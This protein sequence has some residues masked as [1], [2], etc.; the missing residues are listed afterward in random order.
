MLDGYRQLERGFDWDWL[1]GRTEAVVRRERRCVPT[2]RHRL[3]DRRRR[4]SM[5]ML[6]DLAPP[7]VDVECPKL[8][9]LAT[10]PDGAGGCSGPSDDE[11]KE[12]G[13]SEALADV[14]RRQ[15]GNFNLEVKRLRSVQN[16]ARLR[17]THVWPM[18]FLLAE[19]SERRLFQRVL[20]GDRKLVQV[21]LRERLGQA[22]GGTREESERS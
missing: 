2:G 4:P 10:A 15:E 9:L 18:R 12:E 14:V 20:I 13:L 3:P 6:A 22:A 5:P 19:A 1:L 11:R 16:V 8:L 21:S 17:L 7:A